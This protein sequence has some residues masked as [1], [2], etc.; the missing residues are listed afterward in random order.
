MA[1]PAGDGHELRDRGKVPPIRTS[2]QRPCLHLRPNPLTGG[3]GAGVAGRAAESAPRSGRQDALLARRVREAGD[4]EAAPH[5]LCRSAAPQ[6]ALLR[7]AHAHRSCVPHGIPGG[8]RGALSALAEAAGRVHCLRQQQPSL[9]RRFQLCTEVPTAALTCSG[10]GAHARCQR[11]AP[12]LR[13]GPELDAGGRG[14]WQR[15]PGR[16]CGDLRAVRAFP[17]CSAR[18]AP[19]DGGDGIARQPP[20][21]PP[22]PL[23]LS[24][25]VLRAA[26]VTC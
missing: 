26:T 11:P 19:A 23:R 7:R 13:E 5:G 8:W 24:P 14:R 6:A 10:V 17:R 20:R 12:R 15:E 25:A 16:G 18:A 3:G 9:R 21:V 2:P 1:L 22:A 4:G